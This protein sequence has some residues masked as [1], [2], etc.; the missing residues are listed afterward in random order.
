VAT[1]ATETTAATAVGANGTATATVGTDNIA[2][3][4]IGTDNVT[5][6]AVRTDNVTTTAVGTDN[7]TGGRGRGRAIVG[8]GVGHIEATELPCPV[9]TTT[10]GNIPATVVEQVGVVSIGEIG[11][12]TILN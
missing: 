12:F 11:P 3:A 9:H 10:R 2:T 1:T 8:S 6:T 5:T 7:A 4:A